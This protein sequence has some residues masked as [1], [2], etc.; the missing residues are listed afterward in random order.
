MAISLSGIPMKSVALLPILCALTFVVSDD[1]YFPIKQ[2]ADSQGV[3]ALQAEWYGRSLE[4]MREPRLPE[5]AKNQN[6]EIYRM[7]ILPTWGNSIAVRVEKHG[8][9]YTLFARRLSG[10]AGYEVGTLVESRDV[11]LDADE[12]KTLDVLLGNFFRFPSEDK[13]GGFDGDEWILE[14]VSHGQ[15]H[16]FTY[17]CATSYNPEKRG[18]AAFVALSKFLVDKSTLSDRPK[19]KG[20]KLI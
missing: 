11:E 18:L 6:A 14:S 16:V 17:W 8:A 2:N 12:S 1:S 13:V 5:S 15:Y 4:Q 7:T 10:Q 19:N 3:T 20:H 9:T